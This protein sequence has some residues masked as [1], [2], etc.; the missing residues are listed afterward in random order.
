MK[1]RVFLGGAAIAGGAAALGVG[2]GVTG[3][4]RARGPSPADLLERA[5][6]TAG[7]RLLRY[8]GS[9]AADSVELALAPGSTTR[10]ALG[11]A[12]WSCALRA[13]PVKGAGKGP[14]AKA[15][16]PDAVEL[17]AT[18]KLERGAAPEAGVAL[19]LAFSRWSR[20]N[21]VL[22][23]GTCYAGNRFES[24]HI[25]Y[26]PLLTEAA[27]IGPNVPMIVSDIPRLN[28]HGGPSRLQ[29]LAADLATPAVGVHAPA[30]GTGVLVLVDPATRAGLS[31]LTLEES[32]DRM[33]ARLVCSAPGVREDVA[34]AVGN[35]RLPSKDRGAA[36]RA[37]DEIVLRARLFVFDCPEVQGLFD[38]LY[39]VRKDLTGATARPRELPF[40]AAFKAHE[41]RTNRRWA[42][43]AGT[44]KGA[45]R[46][47]VPGA[48]QSGWWGGL[49]TTLPL[50]AF[51]EAPS[52]ARAL[53]TLAFVFADG[54]GR[55]GFFHSSHDGKQWLED[56]PAAPRG[57]TP[58]TSRHVPA[59]KPPGR[60]HL[61]R[62]SADTL[63]FAVK[64]LMV[65]ARQDADFKPE[66][67]VV[68]GV[69][70]CADAFVRLWD[71]D[72]QF[73]Q[74]VDV[75]TGE[76]VV[77]GSTSGG[78]APAGL[79]LAGAYLKRDDCLAVAHAA[80]EQMYE[81]YV[82]A[83]V[84][85]GG[86]GDALQCPDGESAAG[87]LESFMTLFEQTGERVWLDRA[88]A[89][90]RQVA[91]WVISYDFPVAGARAPEAG[92]LRATGA[93]FSNVQ[94]QRGAPGY[95]L[96][97]GDALFRLYRATGDATFI[98]LLRDT[99]HNLAQYLP[100]AEL[101]VGVRP[102]ADRPAPRARADTSDWVAE[103]DE[104]AAAGEVF[105]SASML[106]Y[107]EVP[108]VYVRTDTAFVFAF[109]HVDAQVR[110]RAPG[111]LVLTIK[112]PTS[113]DASVRVLAETDAE[114]A[115]PLAP[116]AL[117]AARVVEIPAGG[118]TDVDFEAPAVPAP[119]P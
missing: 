5:G 36:F 51:G 40:S 21:Y 78:L 39:L 69:G 38:K 2:A 89:T 90:A 53:R 67:R 11:D 115:H 57:P 25:A 74:Y 106:S 98:E 80:G 71:R 56:G 1:R 96:L 76:I 15:A 86:P 101:A 10:H 50:L 61:V 102:P 97:S 35:T 73:G 20:G 112:N 23:P 81:R 13:T 119:A 111:R 44:F 84:T 65:L 41:A 3:R 66:G 7:V 109:D 83:G 54:Q 95:T 79:A 104:L 62:R 110:E 24:R 59:H 29:V 4:A 16:R 34:Y 30:S 17:V 37:G 9:H 12:A 46:H 45:A 91:S 85:C 31:G 92:E 60:W 118:A 42:E 19:V 49:A 26:P 70:R 113:V 55:S 114:A 82:R 94:N 8:D 32:D 6:L 18:F 105:D 28:V 103:G 52:R 87:L 93:I 58:E 63:T 22:L 108:G 48:W 75:D 77:G 33:R 14:G 27:D 116:G 107:T 99:V 100:R 47:G 64:Q 68:K 88:T 43:D 72:K 117:L